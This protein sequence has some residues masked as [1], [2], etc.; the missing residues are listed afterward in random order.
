[1]E[2]SLLEKNVVLNGYKSKDATRLAPV[3]DPPV[4][5]RRDSVFTTTPSMLPLNST[6]AKN[7]TSYILADDI[8]SKDKDQVY[9]RHEQDL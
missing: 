9:R 1:M 4:I 6:L 7:S 3:D 8:D 2:R 5:N